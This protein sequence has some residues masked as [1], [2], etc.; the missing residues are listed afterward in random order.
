MTYNKYARSNENSMN[1]LV[2]FGSK[3]FIIEPLY[4]HITTLFG[5][6][7]GWILLYMFVIKYVYHIIATVR[8]RTS[9]GVVS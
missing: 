9:V 3:I 7:N 2:A 8:Q 5:R 6:R 4:R 1:L